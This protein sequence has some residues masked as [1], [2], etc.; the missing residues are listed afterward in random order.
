MKYSDFVKILTV[1]DKQNQIRDAWIDTVPRDINAAFFDNTYV[2]SLCREI[3]FLKTQ[4]IPATL[5]Y[6]IDWFLYEV[7]RET[8][9]IAVQNDTE[10]AIK[11]LDDF[12]EL[13]K[14]YYEFEAE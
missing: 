12:F 2:N 6:D 7:N 8:G 10:V 14:S 4:L 1:L 3:D 11:T 5:L 13:V 9:S